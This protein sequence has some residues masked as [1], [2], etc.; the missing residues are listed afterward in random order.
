MYEVESGLLKSFYDLSLLQVDKLCKI[1][2]ILPL[3]NLLLC[4]FIDIY[5]IIE[6]LRIDYSGFR[7]QGDQSIS[8]D[9]AI[10]T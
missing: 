6:G 8:N 4:L 5:I 1:L 7:I 10:D 3:F 9:Q 2:I